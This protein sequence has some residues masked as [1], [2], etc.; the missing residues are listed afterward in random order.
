MLQFSDWKYFSR[1][2][3]DGEFMRVYPEKNLF[4]FMLAKSN[5]TD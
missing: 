2:P 1:V 3:R 5:G 4:I